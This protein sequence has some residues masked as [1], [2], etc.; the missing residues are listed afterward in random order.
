MEKPDSVAQFLWPTNSVWLLSRHYRSEVKLNLNIQDIIQ[1][2]NKFD[3]SN[4]CARVTWEDEKNQ[5]YVMFVL[6]WE[7]KEKDRCELE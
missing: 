1:F 5:K 4:D 7:M 3:A 6:M 2:H